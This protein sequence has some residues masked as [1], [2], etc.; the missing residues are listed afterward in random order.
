M[1]IQGDVRRIAK[2][3]GV[4]PALIQAVVVAEGNIIRAVQC[5]IPTVTTREAALEVTCRSAAH[6]MSDFIVSDLA[7]A[8]SFVEFWGKRWAPEGADNDPTAL[9]ANWPN[10]VKHLWIPVHTKFDAKA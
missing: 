10:N 1:L 8:R 4:D 6:A 5:S 2:K 3:F 7:R 9:N